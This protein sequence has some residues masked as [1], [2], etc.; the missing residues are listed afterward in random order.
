MI[1]EWPQISDNQYFAL[2]HF[3]KAG[4]EIM[5]NHGPDRFQCVTFYLDIPSIEDE[6]M[7]AYS[8]DLPAG[9]A[10]HDK[11]EDV[12]RKLEIEPFQYLTATCEVEAERYQFPDYQLMISYKPRS[13]HIS[14]LSAHYKP[15]Q[16]HE[17]RAS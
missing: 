6:Y 11:K 12:Q 5:L 13:G 17:T 4:L 10:A 9:I 8:R 7:S 15:D 1:E 14:L 16:T 3:P 2:Y